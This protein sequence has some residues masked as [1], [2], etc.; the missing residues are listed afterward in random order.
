[1]YTPCGRIGDAVAL[2]SEGVRFASSVNLLFGS[3]L[4]FNIINRSVLRLQLYGARDPN[5]TICA[6]LGGSV[7]FIIAIG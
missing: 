6:P 2:C 4:F 5:W 1:M 7:P 3:S